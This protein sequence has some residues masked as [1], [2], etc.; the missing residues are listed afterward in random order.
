MHIVIGDDRI[1]RV[2]VA[3]LQGLLPG[4]TLKDARSG[5][6][7][8]NGP[9]QKHPLVEIIIRNQEVKRRH[10][11]D[12]RAPFKKRKNAAPP[13]GWRFEPRPRPRPPCRS[14]ATRRREKS[15]RPPPPR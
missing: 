2:C 7:P 6:F 15:G 3:I 8:R 5:K 4:V 11:I 13:G 14:A 1:H 12:A 9:A 10:P